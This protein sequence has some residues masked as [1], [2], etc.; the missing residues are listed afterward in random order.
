MSIPSLLRT[1][2]NRSVQYMASQVKVVLFLIFLQAL[3]RADYSEI[4]SQ[5][6]RQCLGP[7]MSLSI[8]I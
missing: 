8:K 5:E 7:Y 2:W 4:R 6:V 3:G 1:R